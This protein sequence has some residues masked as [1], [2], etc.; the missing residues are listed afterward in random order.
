MVPVLKTGSE[1]SVELCLAHGDLTAWKAA[2]PKPKK[3]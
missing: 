2:S 1:T 3:A